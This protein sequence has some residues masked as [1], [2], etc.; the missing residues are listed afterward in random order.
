MHPQDI[1]QII[2]T[3]CTTMGSAIRFSRLLLVPTILVIG[4]AATGKQSS[5]KEMSRHDLLEEQEWYSRNFRKARRNLWHTEVFEVHLFLELQYLKEEVV[6]EL[7]MYH[8]VS[9]A[10]LDLC[11]CIQEQ[12]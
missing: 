8:D 9:T 4:Y 6:S 5:P 3:L 7:E 1:C 10:G 11:R 2:L 12:V